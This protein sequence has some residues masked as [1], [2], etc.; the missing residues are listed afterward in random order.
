LRAFKAQK[1][2]PVVACLMDV[3]T[4]G[5]YYMATAADHIVAHPTTVTGGIGVILNLYNLEDLMAQFN[6]IGTPIKSGVNIDVG[7]PIKPQTEAGRDIL[8]HMADEFHDRFRKVVIEG[9][10]QMAQ[11]PA[12]VYDGR[13][14]SAY[15]ALHLKM[16]DSIGY[17]DDA[18]NV[19]AEMGGVPG[20]QLVA[21]HRIH[22]KAYTPYDVTPN[23]PL[24]STFIPMSIPGLERAK[25]P[26]FLYLWQPDPTLE[27]LTAR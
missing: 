12:D 6:I 1:G 15:Q 7:T 8:Q 2:I 10:P 4:G 19:A 24:Q 18:V 13:V 23:V 17:L 16:I 21:F 20:A 22:D 11:A 26:T 3:S 27:R 14:F 25:L 9:R 5:A